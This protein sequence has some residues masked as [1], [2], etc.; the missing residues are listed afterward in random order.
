MS[1]AKGRRTR[2]AGVAAAGAG[3]AV[4]AAVVVRRRR[5]SSAG[6]L[7]RIRASLVPYPMG[8]PEREVP[9]GGNARVHGPDGESYALRALARWTP[10]SPTAGWTRA[11]AYVWASPVTAVG[12]LVGLASGVRPECREGVVLFPRAAG[13]S[14][15]LLR[16]RG[17]A[18]TAL[19]HVV[20]ATGEP[21][22]ALFAHELVHVH[23]AE[24][25]GP[26]F[27][28]LYGLLWLAYGYARHPMERA[29]RLGGRKSAGLSA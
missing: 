11:L 26:L 16:R 5:A 15:A 20:V 2:V 21:S 28:P 19:G 22:R 1:G 6:R 10:A 12:L 17:F 24:R 3:A 18:A 4:L 13:I 8:S 27:P 7:K 14:G 9:V 23:Q 25:L 29:A